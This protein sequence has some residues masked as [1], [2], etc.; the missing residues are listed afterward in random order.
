MTIKKTK[1]FKLFIEKNEFISEGYAD[2]ILPEDFSLTHIKPIFYDKNDQQFYPEYMYENVHIDH[3]RILCADRFEDGAYV[4]IEDERTYPVFKVTVSHTIRVAAR[5][6]ESVKNVIEMDYQE[7]YD[8]F[9]IISQP[10]QV[11][12]V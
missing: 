11:T 5:N 4:V 12:G 2:V 3:L 6:K 1:Q 9:K 10:K 7:D 8:D